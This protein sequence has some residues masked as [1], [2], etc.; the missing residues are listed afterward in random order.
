MKKGYLGGVTLGV[1][2]VLALIILGLSAE[3]VPAGYVGVVYNM[4]TGVS[5]ETLS[6]GWHLIPPTKRV[7]LYSIGIEQSYLTS[8]EDGDS[9]GDDSFSAPSSDGKGL[10]MELTFTYRYDSEKIA[11]TFTRFKGRDGKELLNSFIKPNIISWTKEVTAKYPVTD[12]L[13]EKRAELNTVLSEYLAEKFKPYG[14]IIEN[15]SL[16]NIEVDKETKKS[17]T[18][19]VKAQQE[20]ELAKIESQ[21]A[22]IQAEKDKQVALIEAEKNKETAQIQAE[23]AKI[24]AQGEADAKKIAADAEAQAN[25]KISES[26]TPELI[27]KFKYDKWDGQV[28][29]IT[30]NT[31]PIVRVDE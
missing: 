23:Q 31:T 12:I 9:K 16:I 8:T 26:L 17:I 22:Q 21:T 10:Q 27:E 25:K 14:I 4:S 11:D 20:L 13:G 19:K 28:S 1:I 24:K 29:K 6:Q 18:N 30:G 2:I 15:A 7:T 5:D 3:R